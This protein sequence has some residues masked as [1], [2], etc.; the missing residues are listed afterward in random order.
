MF[1]LIAGELAQVYRASMTPGKEDRFFTS[2]LEYFECESN[3]FVPGKC[4]RSDFEKHDYPIFVIGTILLF[5]F[6]PITIY[7]IAVVG[8]ESL[9]TACNKRFKKHP[10]MLKLSSFVL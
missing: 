5:G 1:L 8:W 7:L 3:G 10:N 6:G 9:K 4:D 2:L